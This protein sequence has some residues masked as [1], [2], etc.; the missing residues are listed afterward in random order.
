MCWDYTRAA[1]DI[2][3]VWKWDEEQQLYTDDQ[4]G[5]IL[6]NN[7]KFDKMIYDKV[8]RDNDYIIGRQNDPIYTFAWDNYDATLAADKQSDVYVAVEILNNTGKDFWGELNLVRNGGTFYLIGKLD[9]KTAR[10]PDGFNLAGMSNYN[11]PPYKT[12]DGSTVDAPRVFMQ[13]YVTTADIILGKDA[14]KHAYVTMPDLRSSQITLGLVI[15]MS[16]KSGLEF[17]V[18]IGTE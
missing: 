18:N 8:I 16:W 14:L 9:M 2:N 3:V 13:N 7:N 4:G 6:F 1:D 17:N 15:D 12:Q 5:A 11:Y 10:K